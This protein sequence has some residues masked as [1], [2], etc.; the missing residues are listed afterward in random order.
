[1]TGQRRQMPRKKVAILC[2]C[3]VVGTT[4]VDLKEIGLY[5]FRSIRKWQK[6][7]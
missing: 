6:H 2:I 7:V 5:D 4:Y 1:M 3:T